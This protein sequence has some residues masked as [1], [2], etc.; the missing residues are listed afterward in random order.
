[1]HG[2]WPPGWEY[3]P[4]QLFH[5]VERSESLLACSRN[6]STCLDSRFPDHHPNPRRPGLNLMNL[7]RR[8]D[9]AS[10]VDNFKLNGA[11]LSF[12]NGGIRTSQVLDS[13]HLSTFGHVSNAKK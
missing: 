13:G 1:M 4:H 8:S 10:L 11:V 3:S 6:C 2:L 9:L 12:V 5:M 7:K